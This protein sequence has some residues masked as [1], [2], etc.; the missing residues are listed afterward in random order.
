MKIENL[1][2]CKPYEAEKSGV[3]AIVNAGKEYTIPYKEAL[4]FINFKH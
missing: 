1:G 2:F 4:Y 3:F